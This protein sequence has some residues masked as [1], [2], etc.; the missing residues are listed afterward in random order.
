MRFRLLASTLFFLVVPLGV[1]AQSFVYPVGNPDERPT[2]SFPNPNGYQVTREYDFQGHSGVDLANGDE[3][4]EIRAVGA[5]VVSLR[6]GP[7]DSFGFGN[8]VLIRHDLPEGT[9]YSF[10]AHLQEGTVL[11]DQGYPV[12][13]GQPIGRVDCTGKTEAEGNSVCRSN[14]R[15]GPHLHFA[16]KRLNTLGCAYINQGSC[17]SGDTFDNYVDPL[18]FIADHRP[19]TWTRRT[20]VGTGP[21]SG[22][23]SQSTAYDAATDTLIVF[24]GS[25]PLSPCCVHSNDTWILKNASGVGGTPTWEKLQP[26][27]PSGLPQARVAHS[28]VYDPATNRMIVFGGGQGDGF[29]FN[30]LFDDVWILYCAN[31]LACAPD[32]PKWRQVAQISPRPARREGHG[33]FYRETT[34]EMFVF[35]GGNNGIMSVPD[36]HWVLRTLPNGNDPDTA[37]WTQLPQPTGEAPGRIEHFALAYDPTSDRMTIAGGCCFYTNQARV[38]ILQDPSGTPRW[39]NLAP[40]GTLPPIGDALLFG[41]DRFSNR[42]IVQGISP[43]GGQNSTWALTNANDIG[44]TPMWVNTIPR[45]AQGSPPEGV[46]L[47]GSAYNAATKKFILALVIGFDAF[48]NPIPEVWVLSNAD[49]IPIAP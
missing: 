48:G 15:P 16:I 28:A 11:V 49:Q 21:R 12:T 33:A 23:G 42:L 1:V 40:A 39:K 29:A 22:G 41:Y 44:G 26:N 27:A 35:G 10:Y 13:A 3:G 6:M 31:N 43:G 2:K 47:V 34:K 14:N 19:P 24:G 32:E 7:D 17:T 46:L 36:D 18:Q 45:G 37:T 5:G 38:L 4:G 8:V 25:D 20:P 30:P 9:F